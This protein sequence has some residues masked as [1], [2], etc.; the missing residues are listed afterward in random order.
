M[1]LTKK[2]QQD[3]ELNVQAEKDFNEKIREMYRKHQAEKKSRITLNRD[4]ANPVEAGSNDVEA[5][6]NDKHLA[7][8]EA[9]HAADIVKHVK[10]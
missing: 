8:P 7:D 10:E 6:H 4:V 2:Q 3:I 9:G 1:R 5:K